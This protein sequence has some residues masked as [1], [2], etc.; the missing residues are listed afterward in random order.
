[1]RSRVGQR[2]ACQPARITERGLF[3]GISYGRRLLVDL[4]RQ[5][6]SSSSPAPF[7]GWSVRTFKRVVRPVDLVLPDILTPLRDVDEKEVQDRK[8]CVNKTTAKVQ[9]TNESFRRKQRIRILNSVRVVSFLSS[10]RCLLSA[11]TRPRRFDNVIGYWGKKCKQ[12]VVLMPLL[13][14]PDTKLTTAKEVMF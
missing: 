7:I 8:F 6:S 13:M 4:G 3:K 1:M 11:M 14:G 2:P 12:A 5:D 9:D 10:R